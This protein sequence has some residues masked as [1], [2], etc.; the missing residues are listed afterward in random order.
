M[1]E[2][3]MAQDRNYPGEHFERNQQIYVRWLNG[4][5]GKDLAVEYGISG[6]RV[7]QIVRAINRRIDRRLSSASL[8]PIIEP[9]AYDLWFVYEAGKR[10][11]IHT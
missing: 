11:K 8:Y 2:A 9:Y 5:T 3:L 7:H 1:P 4:E 6:A 10:P